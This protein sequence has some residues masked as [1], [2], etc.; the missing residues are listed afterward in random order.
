MSETTETPAARAELDQLCANAIRALAIDGVQKANSGHPGLP[1]GMADTAY[2]LWSKFLSHNPADP[3]WPNRDR[4]VL[5]AGHGS[6]LLYALLHL[7]GYDLSIDDL[8]QFRQVGS[9]TPGH[10]EYH[11]TPGV[12]M[13]TGPLGQG[14]ATA[15]GMALAERWLATTLNRT[16]MNVV[17]HHT[18]VLCGDG[19][20]MEGIS[21]EAASLAGHLKLGKLICLYDSNNI[22]LV[23]PTSLSFS[24]NIAERFDS[25]GWQVLTVDGHN[26]VEVAQALAEAKDEAGRPSM[27]ICQTHIGYGSP[28]QD[29]HTAHGE[30]LGAANVAKTKEF[31]GWPTEPDFYVPGEVYEHMQVALE[32]GG[33]RQREWEATLARY[34]ESYPD[35]GALWDRMMAKA[36]PDDWPATLP[37]FPADPKAKGTRVASGDVLNAIAASIPELLGGS[38]D[39]HSSDQTYLKSYA[40]I[41]PDDFSGRNVHYGVREHAMGAALNG[42]ALHGG[43]IPYGGTFFVFSDYLRPAIRLA[44]LMKIQVVYVFTH[45]SIGVGEDGPTHQPVEHL[46]ALRSIPNLTVFRAGDANEAAMGWRVALERRDGPTA[47]IFTRQNV[48]TMDRTVVAPA[49]DALRG[50]Y[51]LRAVESPQVALIGTG[52]E[53]GLALEA[54]DLLAARGVAAQVVSL[55]SWEIFEA[56]DQAYRDS[57]LPPSLT[58]RVAVEAGISMGW[59]RYVGPS[60]AMVGINHFGASGPAPELFKKFGFTAEHV[61]EVAMRVIGG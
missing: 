55:P 14:V 60:G 15:V 57:V 53:L 42:M 9:K 29:S 23:G 56:Q 28:K 27:I 16:G 46:A 34:K 39:L 24:E 52:S 21:H 18:Y 1:L 7:T 3:Q 49:E 32:V 48:P 50:G 35:M 47:L 45:D 11:D 13:T 6:M 40:S 8:K 43:V 25:Y 38:A 20:L 19:D 30:P 36:L 44:A 17:D 4:F 58:A 31:F 2:V 33:A 41:A 61:A 37:V 22:S 12:E 51:V 5:S 10:P 54:A 59:D 26:M